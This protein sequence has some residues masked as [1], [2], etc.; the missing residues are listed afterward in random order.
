VSE[1][2]N[3]ALEHFMYVLPFLNDMTTSDVSVAVCDREKYIF[4][5]P[6]NKLDLK[7]VSGTPVKPGT[8]I[9]RAMQDK[10]R[11]VVRGD[12]EAF[13]LPYIASAFPVFDKVTGEVVGG[14]VIIE[15]V[16]KQDALKEMATDLNDNIGV[17]ASTTEEISA[18]AQEIAALSSK[19]SAVAQESQRRVKETDQVLGLIRS[20]AGQT[21]L[22]GLNA[23]IEA[24]RVGEAGRGFGVVAEEIR[25]L[26]TSS[27]ESVKKI[28]DIINGIQSD[29]DQTASQLSQVNVVINQ[30]AEAITHVAVSIQETGGLAHRLDGMAE[31]LSKE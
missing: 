6:S 23:A 14:A 29:S 13:G 31:E 30:I 16:E 21:N 20:I 7:I 15:S 28:S 24:A 2:R 12:K 10:R 27:A 11:A 9:V 26:A 18:Q 19:L 8:A 5:K 3:A 1:E 17:L 22:L 25:K 4:Y